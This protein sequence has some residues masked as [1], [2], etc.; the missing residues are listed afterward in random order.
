MNTKTLLFV[1]AAVML[2]GLNNVFAQTVKYQ[3]KLMN[4]GEP[5][6]AT[7]NMTFSVG[8]TTFNQT[9][10]VTI[11]D[12]LYEVDLSFTPEQA[13]AIM[14]MSEPMLTISF[15]TESFE[16]PIGFSLVA[17]SAKNAD[18]A[19]NLGGQ[20]PDYYTSWSNMI[21]I[22]SDIADGDDVGIA[23]E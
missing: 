8:T 7:E 4:A 2:L 18:N 23:T 15:G 20:S 19:A 17:L 6:S 12:G 5:V 10:D 11:T 21:N 3:G 16:Q 13:Q 14:A 9:Q 1:L 22:P